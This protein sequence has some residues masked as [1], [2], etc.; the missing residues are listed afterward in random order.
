MYVCSYMYFQTGLAHFQRPNDA[1]QVKSYLSFGVLWYNTI[2]LEN[3]F[4]SLQT[5]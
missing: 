1:D 3:R 4:G 2:E 5:Q